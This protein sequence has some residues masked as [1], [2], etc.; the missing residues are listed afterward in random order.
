[1]RS[2][3][4]H[5]KLNSTPANNLVKTL[6]TIKSQGGNGPDLGQVMGEFQVNLAENYPVSVYNQ[7]LKYYLKE[8]KIFP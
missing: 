8:K 6:S 5:K 3:E 2:P 4:K 7:K 1:V